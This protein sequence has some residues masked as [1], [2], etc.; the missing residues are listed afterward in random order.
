MTGPPLWEGFIWK[1]RSD[2]TTMNPPPLGYTRLVVNENGQAFQ[3]QDDGTLEPIG[4]GT[5]T[6]YTIFNEVTNP[7]E[8]PLPPPGQVYVYYYNGDIYILDSDGET[9]TTGGGSDTFSLDGGRA[10]TDFSSAGGMASINCGGAA[11]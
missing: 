9:D 5:A 1:K 4:S 6:F 7:D 11:A 2:L 8:V 3:L 10:G